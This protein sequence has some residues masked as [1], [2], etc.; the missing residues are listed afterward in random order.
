MVLALHYALSLAHDFEDRKGFRWAEIGDSAERPAALG[1][2]GRA[3]NTVRRRS[4]TDRVGPRRNHLG[5]RRSSSIS[6][7]V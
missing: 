4:A 3:E 5:G 1:T 6:E 7:R 2:F